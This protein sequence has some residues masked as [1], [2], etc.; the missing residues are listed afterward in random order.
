[1]GAGG[2]RRFSASSECWRGRVSYENATVIKWTAVPSHSGLPR[3]RMGAA[4]LPGAR[5]ALFVGGSTN[6]YNYNGIGYDGVP[7]EPSARMLSF[8]FNSG[9]WLERP[10]L[11]EPTMDQRG[12]ACGG[13]RQGQR[14]AA[15]T[16]SIEV[17]SMRGHPGDR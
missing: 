13:M 10:G 1:V 3:Y 9:V 2:K 15:S 17:E 14:V 8:D 6:P 5:S 4:A 11:V 16:V 12:L 7:S